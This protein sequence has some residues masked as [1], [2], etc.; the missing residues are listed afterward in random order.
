[1]S[2][3]EKNDKSFTLFVIYVLYNCGNSW[4]EFTI[5]ANIAIIIGIIIYLLYKIIGV[6]TEKMCKT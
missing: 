2:D 6:L 5:V 3:I 1:M 4:I